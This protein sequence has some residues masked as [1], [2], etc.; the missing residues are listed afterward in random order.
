MSC[1]LSV[2]SLFEKIHSVC[3]CVFPVILT[4]L[5]VIFWVFCVG[6][7]EIEEIELVK[8]GLELVLGLD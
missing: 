6:K 8:C 7:F 2:I 5:S 1:D 4:A 3:V